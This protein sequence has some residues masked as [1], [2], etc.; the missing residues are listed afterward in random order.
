MTSKFGASVANLR[1]LRALYRAGRL[2]FGG[3]PV[4]ASDEGAARILAGFMGVAA[5]PPRREGWWWCA[6]MNV[7]QSY[8]VARLLRMS[9][10]PLIEK[11]VWNRLWRQRFDFLPVLATAWKKWEHE[12]TDSNLD[13]LVQTA[14][15]VTQQTYPPRWVRVAREA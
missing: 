3:H 15:V 1:V 4:E 11:R 7:E 6:A 12:R 13:V 5:E 14:A 8:V 9:P 10:E 2:R